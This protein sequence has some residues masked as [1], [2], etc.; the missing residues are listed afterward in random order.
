MSVMD[1]QRVVGN[2]NENK[3]SALL[4]MENISM[5]NQ[6]IICYLDAVVTWH[7]SLGNIFTVQ[8]H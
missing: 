5:D 3:I 1:E 7:C 4:N 8:E 6:T 2:F